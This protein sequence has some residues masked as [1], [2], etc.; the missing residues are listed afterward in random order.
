[1]RIP[2]PS[3]GVNHT[4]YLM[5]SNDNSQML[6]PQ[7]HTLA[8]R[9]QTSRRGIGQFAARPGG[10]THYTCD[11]DDNECKCTGVNDCLNL[12]V[13]DE[14]SGPIVCDNS[15]CHCDWH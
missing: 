5:E 13:S 11:S 6:F 15:G 12:I 8:G 3:M 4:K 7:Q 10:G 14:C 9:H 2:N 1:M